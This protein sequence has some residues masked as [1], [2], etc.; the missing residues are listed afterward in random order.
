MK[1]MNFFSI[2]AFFLCFT[3]HSQTV[4]P[5]WSTVQNSNFSVTAAGAEQISVVNS[6][7]LWAIGFDRNAPTR[8]YS[9]FTTTSNGGN[10]Y[11]TGSVYPDTNS[12]FMTGIEG[13]DANNAWTAGYYRSTVDRGALYHTTNGGSTWVNGAAANM[14]TV[15]GGSFLDFVCFLTSSVGI[16]VGDPVGGEFEIYRTTDG[17]ASWSALAG[18]VIPNPLSGEY[19]VSQSFAKL[20]TNLIWFGTGKNRIY[21]SIDA[22]QT[23]SVSAPLTSTMGAAVQ[24]TDIAF[25]DANNGLLKA[26]FGTAQYSGLTLWKTSNGG[27][28]WT[29]VPTLDPNF[30]RYALCAVPGTS[31][32]ASCEPTPNKIISYSAD[33]GQTWT[34]WGGSGI[35]YFDVAFADNLNGWAGSVSSSTNAAQ[36]GIYK[37]N[38]QPVNLVEPPLNSD[39]SIFPNPNNGK[40]Q[41]RLGHLNAQVNVTISDIFGKKI[42]NEAYEMSFK[43]AIEVK[44]SM[45][46]RGIYFLTVQHQE[47]T[48]TK[49]IVIE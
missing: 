3:V 46:E 30:G 20:G 36:G 7:V 9:W 2:A 1:T 22:G 39:F 35:E 28:T 44:A 23:W 27:A 32:Y 16:T 45:L 48:F 49:R 13:I 19:G 47:T 8:N 38:G 37:Y 6:N 42:F 24:I 4:S 11:T 33:D 18:S 10:S 14:Y 26:Y 25:R 5:M 40:F 41:I 17:G 31:I 15:V 12:Y 29:Q 43:D 34:S 21:R